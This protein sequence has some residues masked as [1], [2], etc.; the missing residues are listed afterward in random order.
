MLLRHAAAIS[1]Y[2]HRCPL[3]SR[4]QMNPQALPVKRWI[5]AIAAAL[6]LG[7]PAVAQDKTSSPPPNGSKG[8]RRIALVIGNAAYPGAGALR[9][10]AND[11]RDIGAKLKRL[12]FDVIL[13]TD[14]KQ[15][16]MLRSLTEFGDKLKP[17]SEAL[18]FYAGHGMQ[19]RGKNYLI[20]I[21]AEIRSESS[22]SSEAVDVDQLLDKLS[23]ARLSMVILDACRNNPFERRFRGS[24]QGLAQINAPTGTLI[25]YATAP[26]KVAADGDGRNGLYTSELLA[27]MDVPGIKI[28]DVFKRVRTNVVRRSNDA[29]TPWESSSLTG[30]FFFRIPEPGTLVPSS[31]A[32]APTDPAAIELAYWDGVKDSRDADAFKSYL[33]QYPDGR[34]AVLAKI[35]LR[36]LSQGSASSPGAAPTR[37][38]AT[39]FLEGTW[40][41]QM[42][43]NRAHIAVRWNPTTEQ[44]E[45][46]LMRHGEVSYWVGFVLGEVVWKARPTSDPRRL[47]ESQL[48]RTGSKGVSVSLQWLEGE[49]NLDRSTPDELVISAGKLRRIGPSAGDASGRASS[50]RSEARQEKSLGGHWV[51][52][53]GAWYQL[54]QIGD[55]ITLRTDSR[56]VPEDEARSTYTLVGNVPITGL[57][58]AE[59][60]LELQG[61]RLS[62]TWSRVSIP[63]DKCVIPPDTAQTT[64]EWQEKDGRM[65][66]RHERT[67]YRAA[68]QMSLLGDDTCASVTALGRMS[69]EDV[70]HGPLGRGG[71]GTGIY[72]LTSW[73]DGGMSAIKFGWQGRLRVRVQDGTPAYLAGLRDEDEILAIDGTPV[74]T[75]SAGEAMMRLHGQPGSSITLTVRRKGAAEASQLTVQRVETQ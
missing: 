41:Y 4:F 30:D 9:N 35:R 7:S 37:T 69:V 15:K 31:S 29:Q 52:R 36:E 58:R 71:L 32:P 20:P 73:W 65:V 8:E 74:K 59:Y 54:T 26:G 66:L 44:Y 5:A 48:M 27:A 63:A 61:S 10:P 53:D 17:G 23:P 6:W 72:G 13:R 47:R 33:D 12:G 62:G 16:D 25:A 39:D 57:I 45:G 49:I 64:G 70:I 18:F 56:P 14:L 40:E 28:E 67:S 34:F 60:Q 46:V 68:T 43:D 50:G 2:N 19:V 21:D 22:V 24:G 1:K 42:P 11:A 75:L 3:Q 51:G 38:S 55:R